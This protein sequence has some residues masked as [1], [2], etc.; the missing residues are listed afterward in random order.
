M[1]TDEATRTE[2]RRIINAG[3]ELTLL[4]GL[5]EE[6]NANRAH[7]KREVRPEKVAARRNEIQERGRSQAE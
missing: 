7:G 5:I 4:E 2:M 1:S 3:W 6:K